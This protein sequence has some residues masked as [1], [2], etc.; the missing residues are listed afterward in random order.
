MCPIVYRY[1]LA[2]CLICTYFVEDVRM[3]KVFSH[4]ESVVWLLCM[5]RKET[6]NESIS[7]RKSEY[8]RMFQKL[9]MFVNASEQNGLRRCVQNSW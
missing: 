4:N 8:L 2:L 5:F 6:Q 7:V 3:Y 9:G 1:L